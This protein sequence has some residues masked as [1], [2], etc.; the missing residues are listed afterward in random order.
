MKVQGEVKLKNETKLASAR[1]RGYQDHRL[2]WSGTIHV[3]TS[4]TTVAIDDGFPTPVD[5]FLH[6]TGNDVDKFAYVAQHDVYT[7]YVAWCRAHGVG[8]AWRNRAAF[9]AAMHRAG[10]RLGVWRD[11]LRLGLMWMGAGHEWRYPS[12]YLNVADCYC[13][14]PACEAAA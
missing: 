2:K 1:P 7:A 6:E 5:V 13:D 10:W 14:C 12:R 3:M 8:L 9:A 11:G 4:P